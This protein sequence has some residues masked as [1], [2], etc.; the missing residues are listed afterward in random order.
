MSGGRQG[1]LEPS[2]PST[3]CPGVL[4]GM[5]GSMQEYLCVVSDSTQLPA[6]LD[7]VAGTEKASEQGY[8]ALVLAGTALCCSDQPHTLK[9]VLTAFGRLVK[10]TPSLV[11]AYCYTAVRTLLLTVSL[12]PVST[13]FPPLSEQVYS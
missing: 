4:A 2:L 9:S 10:H 6:W 11:R 7:T 8:L 5:C 12:D 13:S 1:V 3:T